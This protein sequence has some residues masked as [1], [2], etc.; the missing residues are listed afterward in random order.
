MA[1][2]VLKRPIY[3]ISKS[4]RFYIILNKFDSSYIVDNNN[5]QIVCMYK[6]QANIFPLAVMISNI[7][8]DILREFVFK[9][10]I[11]YFPK[12]FTVKS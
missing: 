10:G 3:R 8:S 12:H 2:Y 5:K 11:K 4:F 6:R 1:N 7:L 9:K